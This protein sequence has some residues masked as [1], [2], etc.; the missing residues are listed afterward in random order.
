MNKN[1]DT[2]PRFTYKQVQA[3]RVLLKQ[4]MPLSEIG[5]LFGVSK[6][7]VNNWRYKRKSDYI[8]KRKKAVIIEMLL[9]GHTEKYISD[10]LW[11]NEASIKQ[12]LD[13]KQSSQKK[14]PKLKEK[15]VSFAGVPCKIFTCPEFK[16][17]N[18]KDEPQGCLIWRLYGSGE[19]ERL[20]IGAKEAAK[21][22]LQKQP[23]R[24]QAFKAQR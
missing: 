8:N 2:I 22:P 3:M 5:A 23:H 17:C 1:D 7:T 18:C 6:S 24:A 4:G 14:S 15:P 11:V 19:K 10:V 13:S 16:W 9:D 20:V 12:F 21:K